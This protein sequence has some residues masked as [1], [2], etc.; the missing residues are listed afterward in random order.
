MKPKFAITVGDPNGIGPEIALKS[1]LR[2]KSFGEAIPIVIADPDILQFNINLFSYD[3]KIEE[4][5]DINN[6]QFKP[7]IIPCFP[8]TPK[9]Y[10]PQ[11]GFITA[12][13]GLHAFEYIKK[14]A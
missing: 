13:A 10:K 5:S 3:L 11:P 1:F 9:D 8:V 7:D 2:N 12:E 14:A 4:Y 6:I